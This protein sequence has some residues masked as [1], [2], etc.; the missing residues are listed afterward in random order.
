MISA[1]KWINLFQSTTWLEVLG[2]RDKMTT[3]DALFRSG[4]SYLICRTPSPKKQ[5]WNSGSILGESTSTLYWEW[6]GE[7]RQKGHMLAKIQRVLRLLTEIVTC[8]LGTKA[9]SK[10]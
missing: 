8:L 10:T 3:G 7:R 2:T 5:C 9:L 1:Y 6:G 4:K